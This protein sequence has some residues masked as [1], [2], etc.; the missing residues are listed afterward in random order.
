MA[1]IWEQLYGGMIDPFAPLQQNRPPYI[2]YDQPDYPP[3]LNPAQL[4]LPQL[5]QLGGYGGGSP[6]PLTPD[7]LPAQQPITPGMNT[8]MPTFSTDKATQDA[9]GYF[10][11]L[12]VPAQPS[13]SRGGV[14]PSWDFL[15]GPVGRVI[16]WTKQQP[17]PEFAPH[18]QGGPPADAAKKSLYDYFIGDGLTLDVEP[19]SFASALLGR[20][21]RLGGT[22][23]PTE[24]SS[25]ARQPDANYRFPDDAISPA[26]GQLGGADQLPRAP[27][28]NAPEL[29]PLEAINVKDRSVRIGEPATEENRL[30]PAA[31]QAYVDKQQ[32]ARA[33]TTGD[34]IATA[35]AIA[36]NAPSSLFAPQ[37]PSGFDRASAVA[38]NLFAGQGL[39]PGIFDAIQGGMTGQRVDPQGMQMAAMNNMYRA[40]LQRGYTSDMAM[41]GA[42]NPEVLKSLMQPAKWGVVR[43]GLGGTKQY[44]FINEPLQTISMP[45]GGAGG[46][47]YGG[48]PIQGNYTDAQW[49][50][51]TPEQ[52]LTTVPAAER[53][54]LSDIYHARVAPSTRN[55]GLYAAVSAIYPDFDQQDYFKRHETL[56]SFEGQG[57]NALEKKALNTAI[58]HADNLYRMI[59]QLPN[60]SWAP[61]YVNP[62]IQ[63]FKGNTGDTAFQELRGRWD[64]QAE[65][66]ANELS[67]MLNGG[68]TSQADRDH[69][70][71]ILSMA[72]SPAELKAAINQLMEMAEGRAQSLQA[73]YDQGMKQPTREGLNMVDEPNRA[74]FMRLRGMHGGPVVAAHGGQV[75]PQ[76][77]P[78]LMQLPPPPPGQIINR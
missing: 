38:H 39:I 51:M 4:K 74:I 35:K 26:A 30:P 75:A 49:D 24:A 37:A 36:A 71:A 20:S 25:A 34:A 40:L 50:A 55:A 2:G 3:M 63:A 11:G 77:A 62:V 23:S 8:G 31:I 27:N 67:K 65:G 13:P 9:P 56:K 41:A 73:L 42:T 10:G 70:R 7:L 1:S 28:I 52:R 48:H 16:D 68:Q 46:G 22:R 47:G 66:L 17:Y 18:G 57:K 54:V 5:P 69:A 72:K 33:Q 15:S 21:G 45:G 53:K 59:D 19:G 64:A 58:T 32:G 60:V 76:Q 12:P 6:P 29:P 14:R 61:G 43:E 44:G 78:N